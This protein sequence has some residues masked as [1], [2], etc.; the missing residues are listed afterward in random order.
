MEATELIKEVRI[1]H[2]F[3][4]DFR[5]QTLCPESLTTILA[6]PV[7]LTHSGKNL[8]VHKLPNFDV[9]NRFTALTSG[10]V[11]DRDVDL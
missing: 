5:A 7:G 8:I 1:L 3:G 4:L 2:R 6:Q 10:S 9:L 11:T